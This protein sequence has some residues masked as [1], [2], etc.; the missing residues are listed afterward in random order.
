MDGVEMEGWQ[1]RC[2][3]AMHT[4]DLVVVWHGHEVV[5]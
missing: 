1:Y 2:T 5:N 4:S 3:M